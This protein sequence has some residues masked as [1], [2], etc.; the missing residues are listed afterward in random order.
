VPPCRADVHLEQR[1]GEGGRKGHHTRRP[2]EAGR[3]RERR[4]ERQADQDPAPHT[5]C[6]EDGGYGE[7]GQGD[8]GHGR[9]E[10]ADLHV[11]ARRG[12]LGHDAGLREADERDEDA[13]AGGDG[14]LQGGG[15][16]VEDH[17]AHTKQGEAQ[18][19]HAGEEHNAEGDGPRHLH[20]AHHA[21]G[22]E[23]V[24]AHEGRLGDGIVG[25]QAHHERREGGRQAGRRHHRAEIHARGLREDGGLD[26][27]DVAHGGEG[28]RAAPQLR[29]H[30]RPPL[31]QMKE[32]L[33]HPPDYGAGG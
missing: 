4:R 11:G 2:H 30:R 1:G 12:A 10:I 25:P 19:Q 32:S 24:L 20:E 26:E 14:G 6:E 29:R 33:P 17:L 28:D 15:D 3:D 21:D 31:S 8:E 27:D 18:E 5:S 16:R 23:E 22:E 9:G 7:T 13:D